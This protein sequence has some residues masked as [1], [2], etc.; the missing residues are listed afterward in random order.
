MQILKEHVIS[1]S[2]VLI[3]KRSISIFRTVKFVDFVPQE[4]YLFARI[5]FNNTFIPIV[6]YEIIENEQINRVTFDILKSHYNKLNLCSR[7][8]SHANDEIS[9][10]FLETKLAAEEGVEIEVQ[11]QTLKRKIRTITQ[12]SRNNWLVSLYEAVVESELFNV[13]YSKSLP[14]R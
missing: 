11:I 6:T 8:E 14:I 4:K 7:F 12:S 1:Y 2:T 3:T 9:N 5:T 13:C 10:V